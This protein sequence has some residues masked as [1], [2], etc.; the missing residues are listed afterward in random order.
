MSLHEIEVSSNIIDVA[1]TS[2]SN[3]RS[4]TVIG[5]LHHQGYSQFEWSVSS[6]AQ[7]PLT[8]RYT[9]DLLSPDGDFATN[10]ER[11]FLQTSF[12]GHL[13][14]LFS[15]SVDESTFT[16]IGEVGSHIKQIS[17]DET[18]IEGMVR[19]AWSPM[20]KTYLVLDHNHKSISNELKNRIQ[21]FNGIGM[22]GI[23][24]GLSPFSVQRVDALVCDFKIEQ[25]VNGLA[26]GVKTL[27]AKDIIFD[28]ANGVETSTS[29][30]IIFSL[31]ENGS[32]FANERRLVSNCTSFL[33]TPAHLILTTSQHL[34]KFVHLT[35]D[36]EGE[37]SLA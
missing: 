4:G 26:E 33:V 29:K 20:S 35:E 13:G 11:M 14:L 9:S 5:V 27:I 3:G 32:L 1:V 30:D 22:D 8:C 34:L 15:K 7:N 18:G 37:S 21:G 24:L 25:A 2:S 36:T 19:C 16:V 6:M 23:E 10:Q 17:L 12:S 28:L 31:A